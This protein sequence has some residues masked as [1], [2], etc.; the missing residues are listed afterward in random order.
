MENFFIKKRINNF[1]DD[2]NEAVIKYDN[3]IKYI[4]KSKYLSENEKKEWIKIFTKIKND[5]IKHSTYLSNLSVL[6]S[7]E[8]KE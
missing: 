1:I 4:K 6:L 5:E 2:E 8:G 3:I 7:K